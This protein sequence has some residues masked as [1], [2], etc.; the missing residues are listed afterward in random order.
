M[1][2]L[3]SVAALM[4][5]FVAVGFSQNDVSAAQQVAAE[6]AQEGP[7]MVFEAETVDYGTIE[8]GADPYR[9]FKFTNTGTEPLIITNAK[10][11][12]G[13]TVPT[14]PKE[15]IGPGEAGEI[16]VRYDTN[17]LGKFTKRVTLTTN[18]GS[19]KQMLT[20][21]GEVVKKPEEPAGLPANDNGMFNN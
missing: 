19:E 18:A 8:Q 9:V 6:E 1:K 10:G 5:L 21:K 16:K 7:Q 4:A 11:S 20:I 17:R 12:C 13:C 3:F 15:P 14:F 2:K